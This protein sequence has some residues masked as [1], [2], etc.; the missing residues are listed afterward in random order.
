MAR[1]ARPLRP[2]RRRSSAGLTAAFVRARGF[3][4]GLLDAEAEGLL[5]DQV[6]ATVAQQSPRLVV[7][8][9]D[10][11]NSGDV[12][13]MAAAEEVVRGAHGAVQLGLARVDAF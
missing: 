7:V 11:V 6:A 12:T 8:S 4:V 9:T 10:H 5:P 2:S 1:W 13:K 3:A